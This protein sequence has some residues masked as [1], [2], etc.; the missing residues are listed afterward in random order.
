[1]YLNIIAQ[2]YY[3]PPNNISGTKTLLEFIFMETERNQL[4]NAAYVVVAMILVAPLLVLPFLSIYN[5]LFTTAEALE[6][7]TGAPVII[8]C[9]FEAVTAAAVS[10]YFVNSIKSYD[11]S[12]ESAERINTVMKKCYTALI[13]IAMTFAFLLAAVLSLTVRMNSIQL[14]SFG[15]QSP[16]LCIMLLCIGIVFDISL[17]FF[18]IM[19]QIIE[20]AVHDVPF[21]KEEIPLSLMKRNVLTM[22]FGL[23]GCLFL[24]FSVVIQPRNVHE[25]IGFMMKRLVP[26]SAYILVYFSVVEILLISDIKRMVTGIAEFAEKL[27]NREYNIEKLRALNRSELGTICN[28]MNV[29]HDITSGIFAEM[30]NSAGRTIKHSDDLVVNMNSTK[31]NVSSIAEAIGNVRNEIQSQSAGVAESNA[32]AEHIMNTIR[33]LNAAIET[34]ASGVVQSSSAVEEMV[35]NINSVTSILEKTS[36]AVNRLGEASDKG[37]RTVQGAVTTA[38]EVLE[39]SAGILQA[40][41]VIQTIA[42]RTNLLAM[43][44]AIE[45]AH[46]GEAGKGFAVVAGEI[47]KLAEQSTAQGKTI[48]DNLKSL[49]GAIQEIVSAIK[50]IQNEFSSIYELSKKVKEQEDMIAAAM[51]ENTSGN[52][53][54]LDAMHAINSS[55]TEV[56]NGSSEMLSGG[57]QIVAEMRNLSAVTKNINDSMN[58]ITEFSRRI[59][60]AVALSSE[61]TG[62]TQESLMEL[63]KELETFKF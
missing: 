37:L 39:Q 56:K 35:A 25:G 43:N 21:S 9:L 48:D 3:P 26:I 23:I 63:M 13:I 18:V 50:Q 27:A 53:Q 60:D 29:L 11:G 14:R 19:V 34:Q 17:L 28:D 1:M 8:T 5:G 40:S 31:E 58:Q 10:F 20:P 61:T 6:L 52:Q 30:K 44:A 54:I 4:S 2:R 12:G 36:E 49:S 62:E 51:T 47:R 22:L 24:L 42:S 55:T 15:T 7:F 32:S 57:E 38:D 16:F 59:S 46:A 33:S 45:S 41:S